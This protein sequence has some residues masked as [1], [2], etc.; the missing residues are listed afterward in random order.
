MEGS[1][2]HSS[3][4]ESGNRINKE[5]RGKSGKEKFRNLN[6]NLRGKPH[7]TEYKMWKRKSSGTEGIIQQ[8]HN[9][10]KE[11]VKCKK[12]KNPGT[13]LPRNLRHYEE[14]KPKIIEEKFPNPKKKMPIKVQKHI[15]HQ[16]DWIRKES[17]V[18]T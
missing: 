15:E 2:E 18:A 4:P 12:K 6:R 1:E 14:T 16:I 13:K 10:L 17:P 7:Q 11:N 5:N 9:S 3:R 8:I